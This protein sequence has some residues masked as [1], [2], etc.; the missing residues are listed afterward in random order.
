MITLT[1]IGSLIVGSIE[2]NI[3]K[4]KERKCHEND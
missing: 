3:G 1:V 2:E 4:K